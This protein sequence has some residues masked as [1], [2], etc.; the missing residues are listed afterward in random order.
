MV[1]KVADKKK[2]QTRR[3]FQTRRKLQTRKKKD[4]VQAV[5][6]MKNWFEKLQT[7]KRG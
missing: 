6:E 7:R 5:K 2:L 4:V 1:R 3:K